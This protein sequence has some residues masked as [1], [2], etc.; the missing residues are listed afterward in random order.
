VPPAGSGQAQPIRSRTDLVNARP[1]D[2]ESVTRDPSNDKRLLV[3]FWGGVEP[4]FGVEVRVVE[5]A[6]DVKI[7][8][9]GGVPPEGRDR[10]C[11][12]LAKLYEAS[13]DLR[14]PLGSRTIIVAK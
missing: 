1:I 8:V 4:C 9:L 12:A 6:T 3:R 10:A 13:V 14:S 5:S 2:P 11:I 7:T